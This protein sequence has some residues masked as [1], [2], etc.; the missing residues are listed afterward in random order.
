MPFELFMMAV[1]ALNGAAAL[2][3]GPRS[4]SITAL[5]DPLFVTVW[6]A[7]LLVGGGFALIGLFWRGRLTTSLTVESFGCVIAGGATLIHAL[8]VGVTDGLGP[9]GFSVSISIAF[10]MASIAR[11]L[12][13]RADIHKLV[14]ISAQE[15]KDTE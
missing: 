4:S 14:E 12:V 7:M 1:V 13:I 6:G 9:R 5:L 8:A 10:T 11:V 15:R 3:S 2:V